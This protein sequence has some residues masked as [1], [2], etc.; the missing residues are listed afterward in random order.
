MIDP[1]H[2]RIRRFAQ[3]S[4]GPIAFVVAF[5]AI[6]SGLTSSVEFSPIL[7]LLLVLELSVALPLSWFALS[8][9]T[10]I[11]SITLLAVGGALSTVMHF[12]IF[13]IF[14]ERPQMGLG[15]LS[16]WIFMGLWFPILMAPLLRIARTSR[17]PNASQRLLLYNAAAALGCTGSLGLLA[18][19]DGMGRIV[20]LAA[21][22][23]GTLFFALGKRKSHREMSASC[24]TSCADSPKLQKSLWWACCTFAGVTLCIVLSFDRAPRV[25]RDRYE[26]YSVDPFNDYVIEGVSLWLVGMSS[27]CQKGPIVGWDPKHKTIVEPEQLFRRVHGLS[28]DNL[29][30]RYQD[31]L[32]WDARGLIFTGVQARSHQVAPP[33]VHDGKLTYY[34]HSCR[35]AEPERI[36]VQLEPGLAEVR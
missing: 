24:E 32:R 25:L 33:S 7:P 23:L 8:T 1:A 19:M 14:C 30:R 17:E 34:A 26:H 2:S 15:V 20:P 6:L 4:V 3:A 35:S 11:L 18:A 9:T 12:L 27:D 13:A 29:A 10:R 28:P 21:L 22:I 16:C 5:G 31:T 36:E